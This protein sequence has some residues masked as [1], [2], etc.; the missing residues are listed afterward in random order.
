MAFT[1]S[2]ETMLKQLLTAFENGKRLSD[3]PNVKSTNPYDLYVEVL[4]TDGESKKA[5]LATLLPYLEEQCA[6]GVEWDAEVADPAC[7]R[8][9]N[10]AL[11][12]TLPIQSRIR[13]CLLDDDGKVVRYLDPNDWTS[14]VRDG[15]EGQVMVEIPMHY[16][17]FTTNGTKRRVMLSEYPLPGYHQVPTIYISAYQA[18]VQR[19]TQ[20]LASVRNFTEDYRGGDN[21]A[22][23]DGLSKSE[24]G[25]P[26]CGLGTIYAR[27]YARKR[28][29]SSSEWNALTVDA[30]KELYWLF[31][32]EYAT[33]NSQAPYNAEPTAEGYKQGGLGAG[34]T[35]IK[36]EKLYKFNG[37]QPFIPCGYTDALGNG[38]GEV[39][40]TMPAE[41]DESGV[42]V[43]VPR[44]RGI[45][46]PFGHIWV[47]ADGVNVRISADVE[48]GG[49]G[50]SKIYVCSD[51]DKYSS[52]G[53][54]GYRH[55][56]NE[57]RNEGYIK[58]II[59]GEDGDL[60]AAVC[61][62]AGSATYFCGY[63]YTGIPTSGES[64]RGLLFGG[65]AFSREN[66]GLACSSSIHVPTISAATVGSRLCFLPRAKV[67]A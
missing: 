4:D 25:I 15:S 7:T 12:K 58:D 33:R 13:G 30:L 31:V 51:P 18:T 52:T 66:A 21:H 24:L 38:T 42:V 49:D 34:V 2:E 41:Y 47:W 28:K 10:M 53:Y 50:L 14:A 29:E 60:M 45:E 67:D 8:V 6:Y 19:S 11:H 17:R 43:K 55:I 59:F 9:G 57:A 40:F 20:K 39:E 3:L 5:A 56:G 63:H 32:V 27:N 64:L 1:E 61:T 65:N 16:R 23:W 46:N 26:A 37:Y 62:G 54:D 35:N 22:D 36:S 48:N 44:Y